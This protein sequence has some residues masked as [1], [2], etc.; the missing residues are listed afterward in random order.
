MYSMRLLVLFLLVLFGAYT[1]HQAG[2][3]VKKIRE[4][5]KRQ[6]QYKKEIADQDIAFM[7]RAMALS[8]VTFTDGQRALS[9][10]VVVKDGEIAGE[11]RDQT[12]ISHDPS[13]HAEVEAIRDASRKLSTNQ[14]KG[15][16]IYT[17][18]YP[19]S[20]CLSLIYLTGIEKIFYGTTGTRIDS[21][22]AGLSVEHIYGELAKPPVER[23]IPEIL[24]IPE[25]AEKKMTSIKLLKSSK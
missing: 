14:L 8:R 9:G 4:N 22:Y 19:C 12:K 20:M 13:A 2:K 3:T 25:E 15:C 11:G 7:K 5:E 1:E 10:S 6:M 21:T 16:S 18:A 23:L 17:S 24:I